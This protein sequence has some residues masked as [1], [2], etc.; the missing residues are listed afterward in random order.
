MPGI[1]RLTGTVKHYDW[2][3]TSFIPSLLKTANTE[4]K[5]FAEYWMGTHPLGVSV[6]ETTEG[7]VKKLTEY[8]NELP[9]LFKIL[10][11]KD[12]LSIQVHPSKAD[13]ET[14][15]ARENKEGIPLD[16]P[17]RSY[18]DDNHKPELMVAL[19]DFWLLHG[20][21]PAKELEYILLNVLELRELLPVYNQSGYAGLYKYVMEM[22]QQEVDRILRP[23]VNNIV[24]V[25]QKGSADKMDED[26][27]AARAALTFSQGDHI[28]RGIFSVYFFN[29]VHLKKGEALFQD[30]GVPHA[31]LEGQN[32]EIMANS[33]NVLRGGLTT[34]YIDVKELLKHVKCGP[35]VPHILKGEETTPHV[36]VYKTP[37]RDFE[38]SA[39]EVGQNDVA[40]A[41]ATSTEIVIIT[42]GRVRIGNA[43]IELQAGDPAAV[44]L[45]GTEYSVTGID[46][47]STVFRASVPR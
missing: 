13:A 4:N 35:T 21:K 2:G 31:Y 44:L 32:V 41:I 37:V 16:S 34:K 3:G 46:K 28:D 38:L 19:G 29:L 20:F 6:V 15:F 7:R 30:A 14:E 1:Y 8:V 27:W 23:L 39:V 22:P 9:Y 5:P 10:D 40:K 18:K 11:V 25:Y 43:G 24:P 36:R 26:F 33:D 47:K 42:E 12:M 45:A 17:Q